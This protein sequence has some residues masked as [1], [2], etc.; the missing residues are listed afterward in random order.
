MGSGETKPSPQRWY[1][2]EFMVY[3][4]CAMIAIPLMVWI[5]VSLSQRTQRLSMLFLSVFLRN[6]ASFAQ[7][8]CFVRP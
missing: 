2:L 3:Y 7:E 8:L 6:L 1:S 4:L 5:P